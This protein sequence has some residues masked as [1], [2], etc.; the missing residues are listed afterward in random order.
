MERI[1]FVGACNPPT[2][3]GRVP[4]PLRFLRYA[5]VVLVGFPTRPSLQAIYG[6]MCRALLRLVPEHRT[7]S[8]ALTQAMLDVFHAC[9]RRFTPDLH[10]HYIF[11]PRELSRWVRSLHSALMTLVGG[12]GAGEA[13][14]LDG[15]VRL[16]LHEGLRLFQDR[17][18]DSEER[19]WF[20]QCIDGVARE[21][22]PGCKDMEV[23]LQRP[24][25]YSSWTSTRYVPVQ[26]PEL[27]DYVR[28]RLKVG[29]RSSGGFV[30][31]WFARWWRYG[32][33]SALDECVAGVLR[34]GA[35]RPAGAVQ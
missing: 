22:F 9:Q 7:H 25:L 33:S 2:D 29:A 26:R 1:Q 3:P 31:W 17:L 14:S 12:A 21:R 16:W 6:T 34:G 27:R 32:G 23:V 20:D 28:A 4:L 15:L 24:V 11:S 30:G 18:V 19:Q 8:D 10:A 5:P 35:R 13:P